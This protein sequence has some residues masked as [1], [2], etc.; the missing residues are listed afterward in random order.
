MCI[1]VGDVAYDDFG[2]LAAEGPRHRLYLGDAG[3][4]YVR[5]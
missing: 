3:W 4:V 2:R 5:D 1:Y